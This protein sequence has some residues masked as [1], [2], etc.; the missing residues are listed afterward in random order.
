M[1]VLPLCR[2][3]SLS[4]FLPAGA[5]AATAILV[6][7]AI[8]ATRIVISQT[9]PVALAFL[10]YLIGFCC[11]LPLILLSGWVRFEVRDL[12]SIALLGIIQ[13][14]ILIVLL[15]FALEFISSGR[16][17]L[18]FATMPLL[19][20]LLAFALRIESLTLL[21]TLA[22][23]LTIAGVAFALGEKAVL[24]AR[25]GDE[26]VGELAAFASSVSGAICSVLYRPYL[27]KYPT[28]SVSA[29]AMLA[30]VGF[31]GVLAAGEGLFHSI[32]R[33]TAA[34]W[35]AVLFIGISSGVGY[36]LWLWALNHSTPTK[37]TAFLALSPLTATG[38]G[39]VVLREEVS[40]IFLVGL[41]CV[42]V[43]L[44]FAQASSH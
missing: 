22:V 12:A 33:F 18:I 30:A 36:Y 14:G 3:R 11:L 42:A 6:G 39:A 2:H 37:V 25:R 40:G 34:G 26:W 20:M 8:V 27:R 31:L 35:L 7:A 4:R 9:S 1:I 13:F 28:L 16:A 10:R 44:W 23:L 5:S 43:G 32:P 19:A 29:F 41:G 17:A 38:L 24:D 15:N 21:K